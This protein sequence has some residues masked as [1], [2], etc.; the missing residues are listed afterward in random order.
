MITPVFVD[1][2]LVFSSKI[3]LAI[4]LIGFERKYEK[5][6]RLNL[7]TIYGIIDKIEINKAVVVRLLMK[8]CLCKIS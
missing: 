6:N 3:S 7:D 4:A 8:V 5:N 1:H 2:Q